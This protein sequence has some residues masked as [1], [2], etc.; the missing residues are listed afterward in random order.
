MHLTRY[1]GVFAPH[2][3]LWATVTPHLGAGAADAV[4]SALSWKARGISAGR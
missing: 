1:Y 2:S 3:T 4:P